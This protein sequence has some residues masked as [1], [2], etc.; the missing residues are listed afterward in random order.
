M[1][2]PYDVRLCCLKLSL[3]TALTSAN[4]RREV[5]WCR[6]SLPCLGPSRRVRFTNRFT[7]QVL[8]PGLISH[9]LELQTTPDLFVPK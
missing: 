7:E 2:E 6:L 9:L 3:A 8:V 1:S 5:F 4:R